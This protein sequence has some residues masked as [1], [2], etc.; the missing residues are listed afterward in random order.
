MIDDLHVVTPRV[1]I[2]L[3]PLLAWLLT[4]H[5]Q[6][7]FLLP[8]PTL[9]QAL[10]PAPPPW[11]DQECQASPGFLPGLCFLLHVLLPY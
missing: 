1:L 7:A 9:S 3:G 11:P 8:L 6:L 2:Q 4:L 5:P 10:L